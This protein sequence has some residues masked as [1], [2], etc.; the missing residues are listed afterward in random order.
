MQALLIRIALGILANAG[1]LEAEVAAEVQALAH[2]EGGMQKIAN[3]LAGAENIVKTVVGSVLPA[4]PQ[5]AV[6]T[7][8][9]PAPSA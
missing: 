7:T 9:T 8:T 4:A 6:G 5:A 2:G 3:V 1:T